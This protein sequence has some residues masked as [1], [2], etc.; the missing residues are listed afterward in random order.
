MAA[1]RER[2]APV[3]IGLP[4]GSAA[5]FV[6]AVACGHSHP[7]VALLLLAGV[8]AL[9][10]WASER[11][12]AFSVAAVA[13]FSFVGLDLVGEGDLRFDHG[14]NLTYLVVLGLAAVA[15]RLV[16]DIGVGWRRRRGRGSGRHRDRPVLHL[17]RGGVPPFLDW[18]LAAPPPPTSVRESRHV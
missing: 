15:G 17:V 7:A 1:S 13:W 16:A 2:A 8:V 3:F 18:P 5:A 14:R 6:A 4:F 11:W 12:V 10:A 9:T